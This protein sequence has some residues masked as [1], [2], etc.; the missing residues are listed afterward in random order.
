MAGVSD[1]NTYSVCSQLLTKT[2]LAW[3]D[4]HAIPYDELHLGKPWPGVGGFY[5][6]DKTVRP[7][8]F[9][10]MSYEEVLRVIESDT[11]GAPEKAR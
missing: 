8:E 6:D 3:L 5:V 9:L 4:R 2:L 1:G 7:A 10:A 11:P